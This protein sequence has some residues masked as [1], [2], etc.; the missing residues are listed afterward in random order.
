MVLQHAK[1]TV[2]AGN[3]SANKTGDTHID[4]L[5]HGIAQLAAGVAAD[6]VVLSATDVET[7]RLVITT[8]GEYVVGDPASASATPA[9]WGVRVVADANMPPGQFLI[10]QST[11]ASILDREEAA[12][13]ISY[14]HADFFTRNLAAI[15]CEARV[16]LAVFVPSAWVTGLFP[17]GSVTQ[18]APQKK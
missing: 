11:A 10:G 15:R 6:L 4:V 16:G 5:S 1:R 8:Q 2:A 17:A 12:I 18:A 14:E 7:L 13:M 3:T 9:T